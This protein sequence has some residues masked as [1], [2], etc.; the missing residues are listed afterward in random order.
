MHRKANIGAVRRTDLY[1]RADYPELDTTIYRLDEFQFAIYADNFPDD[2]TSFKEKFNNE[3][4]L[5]SAIVELIEEVPTDY[6]E[7]I[8]NIDDKEISKNFEG[9][10]MS[11]IT[12]F[13][14]LHSKFP[15]IKFY[16]LDDTD[17]VI[18]IHIAKYKVQQGNVTHLIYM[19]KVERQSLEHF[20]A[21]LNSGLEFKIIEE[22]F[23]KKPPI[24]KNNALN[25]VHFIYAS[26]LSHRKASDFYRRDEALW[27]DKVDD[28]FQGN[29]K[30]NDLYFYE[31]DSYSC[32]VDFSI[33]P[34]IDLRNHLFLYELIYL[35]PPFEKDISAWLKESKIERQEFFNL[36][37]RKRIKLVLTQP[38][39]R[40]DIK[41]I[42]AIYEIDE[43]AVITRRALACMQQIDLV[44]KY[45]NYLFKD[46]ATLKDIKKFTVAIAEKLGKDPKA[47]YNAIVWPVKAM[48]GSFEALNE[49]GLA[50]ASIYGVNKIVEKGAS[51]AFKRDL[52]FEYTTNSPAI[53]LAHSLD[54]T[55]FP[56]RNDDY[57][58]EFYA[59]TMGTMLNFYKSATPTNLKSFMENDRRAQTGT[60]I[61]NPIDLIEVNDYISITDLEAVLSQETIFPESKK[62]IETLAT[63]EDAERAKK[64]AYYNKEVTRR[65]NKKKKKTGIIDLSTNVLLD[66]VGFFTG[67]PGLGTGLSIVKSGLKMANQ[68]S[69]VKNVTEKIESA[70]DKDTDS[71]NIKYLTKISAVAKIRK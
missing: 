67:I 27:Y 51:A 5:I 29:F 59:S 16:K 14:L 55:Y 28:I 25:P 18:T 1:L 38:E 48:R 66:A 24:E 34:N 60:T 2:F 33:F 8:D 44:D 11:K 70:L 52:D 64:V 15:R 3:I 32:Y 49:R 63:L 71:Q 45:E 10:P 36:V 31:N 39:F 17:G 47:L 40:Y 26:N 7:I 21:N 37:E 68:D 46:I 65:V 50:S 9:I 61:I 53:H 69:A 22:Q 23:D 62:L 57:S 58:D 43:N 30:K 6:L 41:F 42:N 4:R 35:T 12:L 19:N 20:L 54:A 13:N 56:F